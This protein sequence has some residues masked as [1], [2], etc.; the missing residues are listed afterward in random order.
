MSHYHNEW[1]SRQVKEVFLIK[2]WH[3]ILP[4]W[5][6]FA[7]PFSKLPFLFS[8]LWPSDTIWRYCSG[9]ILA[10]VLPWGLIAPSHYLNQCWLIISSK[11]FC[12]I[13]LRAISSE[14]LMNFI[15]SMPSEI[16]LFK[17]LPHLP[18]ANDLIN[19]WAIISAFKM[20]YQWQTSTNQFV[21]KYCIISF[22][23]DLPFMNQFY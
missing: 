9:S 18:K 10:Q 3:A 22:V 8:S 17:L 6:D 19:R 5:E 11:V 14:G 16:M 1:F 15:R 23:N 4:C 7:K 13:H 20:A 21:G 2:K 12:G